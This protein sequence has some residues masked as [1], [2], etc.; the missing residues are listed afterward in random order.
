MSIIP[1]T[2][3]GE[4]GTFKAEIDRVIKRFDH[5]PGDIIA[6]VL[7]EL[8]ALKLSE[9]ADGEKAE[10]EKGESNDL[11]EKPSVP[12]QKP[13]ATAKVADNTESAERNGEV[14]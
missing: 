3:S 9:K 13:K 2:L 12:I 14:E 7:N 6:A 10:G 8:D 11:E 5:I 1:E 4:V